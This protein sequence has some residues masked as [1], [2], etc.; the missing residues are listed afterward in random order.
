MDY[1]E[2]ERREIDLMDYWRVI[3][4]RK[5]VA[6]T[7]ASAVVI[8]TAIFTF[9]ATPLYKATA[10]LLVE[11]EASKILSIEDEFGQRR[12][13]ADMRFFNTQIKLLKSKSLAEKV[14]KRLNL[15]SRPEFRDKRQ[16]KK[17]L[18]KAIKDLI[19]LKWIKLSYDIGIPLNP[20]SII[21]SSIVNNL[22]VTPVKGTKLVEVSC[23]SSSPVLAAEI[24]NTLAEEFINFS[25]EKRYQS[26]QQASDFLTEQI[27]NLREDLA[28]KERELQKYGQEKELYFLNNTENIAVNK[29]AD[30]ANAY[31]QAL[32]D[33]IRAE[34]VYREL[35]DLD[36]DSLPQSVSN[37]TIQQLNA[38]YNRVKNDYMEKI[39][40]FKPSYPEM[41]RLKARLDSIEEQLKK[42]VD[43]VES[44][45]RSALK[46]EYSLKRQLEKQKAEVAKMNSSAILYNSLK[47]EVENMR[48]LFNSLVERQKSTLVSARLG[49]LNTSNVNVIDKAEIPKS[50]LSSKKKN[51]ILAFLIGIFGGVGLCFLL[52]YLDN[53]IKG[54]ED[55]ERLAGLPSLGVVPFLDKEGMRKG[56]SYILYSGYKS[57]TGGN[58]QHQSEVLKIKEI[59]LINYLYPKFSISEDY[60]TVRTS[61][62]LSHPDSPPKTIAFTSSLPQEGKTASAVNMAV[63]FSQL[64]KRVLIVDADLRK[65]KLHKIFKVLNIGGL[66]G[67]LAGKLP[68]KEA[69]QKTS[70]KNIWVIPSGPIPPNPAELLNSNRMKDLIEEVKGSFDVVLFDTAPVLGVVDSVIVS[71]LVDIT[72]LVIR[73]GE[74]TRKQFLNAVEE[75]RR[76][77]VNIIGVVFNGLKLK[78]SDYHFMD[79][80][81]YYRHYYY[82]PE[83]EKGSEAEV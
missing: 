59:E 56:K 77:K 20:N 74:L 9:T 63:S 28:A 23:K 55:V 50:P 13:V 42:A 82:G 5:W 35:K 44:D 4:K 17:N 53:T 70:I 48:R 67:Y 60:R 22:E 68:L 41:V 49:S 27:A 40:F 18:M 33:R 14:A 32:I 12:Q 3:M 7:F 65:P 21:A 10:T 19:S 52:E 8:F 62:L 24:T 46:R 73:A 57:Q 78:K 72:I 51:L 76:A 54:P 81:R 37:P 39:K 66:S 45:Y 15:A 47:I 58:P 34:A 2:E 80:Y 25:I 38:E 16:E 31:N 79:Y 6:V 26:T 64:E 29:L 11:E 71:S 36:V 83:E 61:I 75:M 30:I 69:V 1:K 43:G